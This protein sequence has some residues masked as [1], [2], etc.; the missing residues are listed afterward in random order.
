MTSFFGKMPARGDFVRLNIKGR[1]T[2]DFTNYLETALET[3]REGKLELPQQPIHFFFRQEGARAGLVG[4]MRPSQDKVGRKFPAAIFAPFELRQASEQFAVIPEAFSG[5]FTAVE[6]LGKELETLSVEEL[7]A[8]LQSL[9][10]PRAADFSRAEKAV[11]RVMDAP[12]AQATN[13]TLFGPGAEM[14][15]YYAFSTLAMACGQAAKAP[16]DKLGVTLDCPTRDPAHVTG[17][18]EAVKTLS[19]KRAF[20]PSFFWS[21]G[22]QSKSYGSVKIDRLPSGDPPRM[23]VAFGAPPPLM[24]SYFAKPDL[25]N[26]KLWPLYSDHT[27]AL[28]L[29]KAK[30]TPQQLAAMDDASGSWGAI[31][32]T[33]A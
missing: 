32:A 11:R 20:P 15:H 8:R 4:L 21:A 31:V 12:T 23:L 10:V 6:A 26:N 2:F 3:L 27:K 5:F 16:N 14:R 19:G 13:T 18:L 28:E 9:P 29:T 33:F 17:W 25:E 24:L 30:L 22:E 1:D 7:E